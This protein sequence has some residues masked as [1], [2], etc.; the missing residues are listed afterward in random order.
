MTYH[1]PVPLAEL[2]GD[3]LVA[4]TKGDALQLVDL[5]RT[6]GP[7]TLDRLLDAWGAEHLRRVAIAL[8]CAVD[9]DATQDELWGWLGERKQRLSTTLPESDMWRANEAAT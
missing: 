3:K 4:R 7:E 9:V 2:S 5:V 8:A 6:H 1:A